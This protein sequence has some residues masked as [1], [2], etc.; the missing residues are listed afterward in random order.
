MMKV[1]CMIWRIGELL[2]F[3]EQMDW[4]RRNEFEE[5]SFWS[6]PGHQDKWRGFDLAA[7]PAAELA[8]LKAM[9]RDFQDVD[10]HAPSASW[11][12]LDTDLTSPDATTRERAFDALRRLLERCA[13]CGV[14]VLTLHGGHQPALT[15]DEWHRRLAE[16]LAKADPPARQCNVKI[17][18][19]LTTSYELVTAPALSNTGLTVDTGHMQFDAAA[20]YREYGTLGAL[21]ESVG[22]RV[23][24]MHMH[25][26]DGARD[27]LA[28]GSGRIDFGE[29]WR[30]LAEIG[31]DGSL[32]LELNPD[33]VSPDEIL[34]SRDR[35]KALERPCGH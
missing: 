27:H 21:I 2:D 13:Q 1:G 15:R 35:L 31:Y 30:A 34:K 32:C 26:Y 14:K 5:V 22:P 3:F 9:L 11:A 24:H 4:V 25:D 7:A 20:G 33:V 8:R 19:E 16:A 29:I 6:F 10:I 23:F 18:V 12:S 17:G 28:I